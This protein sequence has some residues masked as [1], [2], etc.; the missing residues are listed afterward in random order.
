L[1]KDILALANAWKATDGC[2]IIG[3]EE[4]NG[5]AASLPGVVPELNDGNI[6]HS[7]IQRRI[8]WWHLP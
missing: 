8:A 1:L 7:S 3:V 5:K 4:V 6:Q 2:I